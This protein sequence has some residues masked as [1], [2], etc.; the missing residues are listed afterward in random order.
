MKLHIHVPNKIVLLLPT[1]FLFTIQ[2][3]NASLNDRGSTSRTLTQIIG[4]GLGYFTAGLL[5]I[6]FLYVLLTRSYILIR[7]YVNKKEYPEV[8]T[9]AQLYYSQY[10][11]P[12]FYIHVSINTVA[13]VFGTIHGLLVL[14]KNQLQ[15]YVGW[16][17]ILI[18]IASSLSG[19]I[20]W[21][22]IRPIWDSKDIRSMIRASHRQWILT[23]LLIF[24]LIIHVALSPD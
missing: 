14:V 20:M 15:A 7:K 18:M 12:L 19:F 3:A 5:V 6:G 8:V 23:F 10:R 4:K 2:I 22:K 16:L 24:V 1:I 21:L 13:I 9:L 11:K 17:A